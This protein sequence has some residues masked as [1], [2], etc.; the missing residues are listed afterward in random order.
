MAPGHR[1]QGLVHP[2]VQLDLVV[3]G[4][5]D[6]GDGALFREGWD[7][8]R[9]VFQRVYWNPLSSRS[10]GHLSDCVLADFF[11][12]CQVVGKV[13]GCSTRLPPNNDE[14]S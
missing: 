3:Q 11:P 10:T 12:S 1:L 9:Q 6:V 7:G 5:E 2:A 4:A 14:L 13:I 8:D